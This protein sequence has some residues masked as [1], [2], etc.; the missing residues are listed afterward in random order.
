MTKRNFSTRSTYQ[1]LS[2]PAFFHG[3]DSFVDHFCYLC[4]VFVFVI[5]SCLFLA[6][7]FN[8]IIMVSRDCCVALPHN[9]TGLS[10]VCDCGISW[11]YSLTICVITCWKELN[12]WL[13]CVWCFLVF[14][15][16]PMWCGLVRV[17][18]LILSILDWCLLSYFHV[19]LN[20]FLS[21]LTP[22]WNI[23]MQEINIYILFKDK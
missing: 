8:A 7:W 18:Y 10:A 2:P 13:S 3:G 9:T 11:S 16:F 19:Q 22:V 6:A 23:N 4:F 15:Y 12:S 14:V 17:W 21:K 5:L 1:G 20:S